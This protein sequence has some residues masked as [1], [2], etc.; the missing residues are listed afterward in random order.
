MCQPCWA[1]P[2]GILKSSIFLLV[3]HSPL[4]PD[5]K[6]TLCS[7]WVKGVAQSKFYHSSC[8]LQP[9]E[10]SSC[11]T[12]SQDSRRGLETNVISGNCMKWY[13]DNGTKILDQVL[14]L[15]GHSSSSHI[16]ARSATML[17]AESC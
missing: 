13:E 10:R 6:T 2:L 15:E 14:S 7:R 5:A 16:R 11:I 12:M 9:S 1:S 4:T 3:F 8:S 17:G